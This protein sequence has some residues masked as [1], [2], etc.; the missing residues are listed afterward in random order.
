MR[1]IGRHIIHASASPN[2]MDIGAKEIRQ[3]HTKGNGWS[4]LGYHIIIRRDGAL[5]WG[6][7]FHKIGSHVQGHNA[8]SIGTCLVGSGLKLSDFTPQQLATLRCVDMELR[9][10]YPKITTHGHREYAN[11]RCPGFNMSEMDWSVDE[12][13]INTWDTIRRQF[14]EKYPKDN[15]TEEEK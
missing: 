6:R 12:A 2:S 14:D 9:F 10:R 8:D 7:P 15:L 4:D 5:E 3:W 1:N 11:K 13:E